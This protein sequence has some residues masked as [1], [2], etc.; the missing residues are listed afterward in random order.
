MAREDEAKRK[1]IEN[2]RIDF[3]LKKMTGGLFTQAQAE[4]LW[5]DHF[6]LSQRITQLAN[7]GQMMI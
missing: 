2:D 4:S 7:R 5:Q 3:I 1:K 6:E